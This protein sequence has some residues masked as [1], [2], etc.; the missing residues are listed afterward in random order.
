MAGDL[1]DMAAGAIIDSTGGSYRGAVHVLFLNADGTVKT[2]TKIASGSNGGPALADY[3]HFG[4][5]L[6]ALRSISSHNA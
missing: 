3:D 5:S 2:K 1:T 6:A 4:G